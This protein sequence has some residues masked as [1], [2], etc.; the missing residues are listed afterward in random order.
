M[1]KL[2]A[3]SI[4]EK[5]C[6]VFIKSRDHTK[7]F[8]SLS[9]QAL[10]GG[11]SVGCMTEVLWGALDPTLPAKHRGCRQLTFVPSQAGQAVSTSGE[12]YSTCGSRIIMDRSIPEW[13]YFNNSTEESSLRAIL[14][15]RVLIHH[16]HGHSFICGDMKG[17]GLGVTRLELIQL[18]R[19]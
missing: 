5:F 8:S 2:I 17:S 13:A 11:E 9:A 4:P 10:S 16:R 7:K 1:N 6:G 12:G 15:F 18:I 19:L 14:N 3:P